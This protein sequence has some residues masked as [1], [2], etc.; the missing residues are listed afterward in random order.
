MQTD[1]SSVKFNSGILK[2]HSKK[3]EL[4]APAGG[5]EA[6]KAAVENGADAVYLG[7]KLFNARA[8]ASNFGME[9][10]KKALVY[11]RDRQVKVYVTVNVLVADSEFSELADYLYELSA[12][13]V[14]AVIVQDIGVAHYIR[15]VLPT[16]KIHASTQ[17]TIN[18]SFGLKQLQEIGFTRVVLARETASEEIERI[19]RDTNMEVEVFVHGAL[20]ISYSGQCL[21]SSYIGARSG[22]RGR[23]AQPCRMAYQLQDDKGKDL[24]AERKIGDHLLSPRDL[25]LSENLA[26]IMKTGVGSIKIEGRMKRPEYVATVV[27]IYRKALDSL[28]YGTPGLSAP[29]KDELTQIF[30]RDFT[31]GYFHGSQG[32]D[33]MS[34]SRPN[35]RGTMLGRIVEAGPGRLVLKL[36]NTLNI[37]DGLEIWTSRGREGITVEKIYNSSGKAVDTVARGET[38]GIEFTGRTRVG[39]RVFKT[40]DQELM[41]K[42]RLSFQEGRES[43]KRAIKMILSGRIGSKIRLETIEG[44]HRVLTE[45]ESQAMEAQNRPLDHEFLCKQLGR[46]GN[47]PFILKELI[48]DISEDLIIPVSEIN[49][50]RRYAVEQ[51][52]E[53]SQPENIVDKKEHSGRRDKWKNMTPLILAG[54]E[55]PAPTLTVALS[56]INFIP[57]AIGAGADRIIMGGEH[58]RFLS[59][60]NLNDLQEA[61]HLCLRRKVKPLW[62]LPRVMNEDQSKKIFLELSKIANWKERPEIVTPN[63]AGIQ[64]IQSL[65]PSWNWETDHFFPVFN[66]AALRWVLK[67]GGNRA[68]LSTELGQEQLKVLTFPGITEQIV[69][70]DME[71]MV[72]EFCLPGSVLHESK[73][74]LQDKCS[75]V[76]RGKHLYIKDR[77][78]YKFPVITDREC[79]MHIFNARKLNLI[80]D[81]PKIADMGQK[82]IRLEMQLV[83]LIQMEKTVKLFKEFWTQAL[84]GRNLNR[85]KSEEAFRQLETIYPEGFT[86]GHFYRGVLT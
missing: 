44:E 61:I 45:S 24:L 5:F 4:L 72:S 37:G 84:E 10:L 62:R 47:T 63:L 27:R 81:L 58:W 31:S 75:Q 32:A 69:F 12:L 21:M 11:A 82:N 66:Q 36:D 51:L 20:C 42:A 57:A 9:E 13:G 55:L 7:G 16:M 85:E 48:T 19:V 71:M 86:K 14:D 38:A 56:D 77:M 18:N 1:N 41:S 64:M 33:M 35:N 34:F 25:N 3:I 29:D 52:L 30:N 73:G 28:E 74:N 26:E 53:R 2:P 76:C 65:D 6:L 46:L 15:E 68:A 17:M 23:C 83:N 78:A 39:D 70:G 40:H 79:R 43:R 54:R 59:P 60:V 80:S 22:N 8:S 49:N 50:L 67:A